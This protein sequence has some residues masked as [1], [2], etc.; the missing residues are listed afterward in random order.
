ML[1]LIVAGDVQV[2]LQIG[3]GPGRKFRP[4]HEIGNIRIENGTAILPLNRLIRPGS[5]LSFKL[6]RAGIEI[7][8]TAKLSGAGIEL[9]IG[10]RP[11]QTAGQRSFDFDDKK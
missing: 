11:A 9:K 10:A 7:Q 3:G 2:Q 8:V 4:V 6:S 5:S 1:E